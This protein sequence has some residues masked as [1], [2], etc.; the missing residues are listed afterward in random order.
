MNLWVSA[1]LG[2]VWLILPGSLICAGVRGW[3][4]VRGNQ[5]VLL[6]SHMVQLGQFRSAF[7]VEEG[8]LCMFSW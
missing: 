6:M 8:S 4:L 3:R 7:I 1:D 5:L 2:C